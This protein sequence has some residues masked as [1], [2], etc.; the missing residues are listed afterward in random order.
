MGLEQSDIFSETHRVSELMEAGVALR[1]TVAGGDRWRYSIEHCRAI[2][3]GTRSKY[4]SF[5]Q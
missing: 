5:I 2:E 1:V 3:N 4:E